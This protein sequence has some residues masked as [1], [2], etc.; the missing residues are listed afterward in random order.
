MLNLAFEIIA[1]GVEIRLHRFRCQKRC[2]GSSSIQDE[3]S[4]ACCGNGQP[5]SLACSV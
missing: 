1:T 4:E 3:G 2:R 5:S